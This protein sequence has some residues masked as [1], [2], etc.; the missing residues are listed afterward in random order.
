MS[1]ISLKSL[2]WLLLVPKNLKVID[3]SPKNTLKVITFNPYGVMTSHFLVWSRHLRSKSDHFKFQGLKCSAETY[4]T[5]LANPMQL[6][7]SLRHINR[8]HKE[9][10]W[11]WSKLN[12]KQQWQVSYLFLVNYQQTELI[13]IPNKILIETTKVKWNNWNEIQGK[14]NK[15]K[16]LVSLKRLKSR[17][18]MWGNY[19][20]RK[21]KMEI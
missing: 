19:N 2:K 6:T 16:I 15:S 4:N 13:I 10:K 1:N 11:K 7:K 12:F 21:K 14:P 8:S 9:D 18:S 3:F 17:L 5:A 20:Q